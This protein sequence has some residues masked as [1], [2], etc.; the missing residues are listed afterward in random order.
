MM[1]TPWPKGDWPGEAYHGTIPVYVV[2]EF[3]NSETSSPLPRE[4]SELLQLLVSVITLSSLHYE[5]V[6]RF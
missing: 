3:V 4:P 5:A 1:P 2:Q 6:R